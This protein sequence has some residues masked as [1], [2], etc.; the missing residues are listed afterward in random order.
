VVPA[1]PA[2]DRRRDD[3]PEDAA[4]AARQGRTLTRPSTTQLDVA[5]VGAGPFGLSVAAHLQD[6]RTVTFGEPTR[7][8]ARMPRGLLL[9]S[10]WDETSLSAPHGRGS[11]D[12]WVVATGSVRAEP[13]AVE[14][15]EAYAAWFRERFAGPGVDSDVVHLARERDGRFVLTTEDGAT[16]TAAAVVLALGVTPFA[17]V[18][19]PFD[20]L[21]RSVVA[22]PHDDQPASRAGERLVVVG[23]GQGALEAAAVAAAA[24]ARVEVLCRSPIRWFADREPHYERGRIAQRLYE[25]AYPVVGYGPPPLNRLVTH[26][27][28]FARLPARA[29]AAATRRLL[30]PGGSA[31]LRARLSDVRLSEG[32]V[33]TEARSENGSVELRLSDGSA[34]TVD[35]L[36]VATG[37]RFQLDRLSFI[38]PRLRRE[39]AGDGVWPRLSTT[40]ESTAPGL[41]FAGYAAE[42]RFG[43]ISRFVLGSA[44][45]AGRIAPAAR[46]VALR[47]NAASPPGRG[48]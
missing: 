17:Y 30:R 42:G 41:F 26:P 48:G 18:P 20:A 23:G 36:I 35:S 14:V 46:A 31:D 7:T 1:P 16:W 34:R 37:Y 11:L 21:P 10:A 27:G 8:W 6:V 9:R 40:F 39:I 29:R 33:V 22:T 3:L 15:F 44:F 13:I 25:L 4:A 43:P 5:V 47:R 12:E 24:G 2:V 38:D 32:V 45:T 19:P 28:L